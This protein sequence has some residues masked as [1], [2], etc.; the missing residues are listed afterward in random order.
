MNEISTDTDVIWSLDP[1]IGQGLFTPEAQ[2]DSTE[3]PLT[4]SLSN[5]SNYDFPKGQIFQYNLSVTAH[6]LNE[7]SVDLGHHTGTYDKL[8]NV[9]I[10]DQWAF[11]PDSVAANPLAFHPNDA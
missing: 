9:H 4:L 6:I 1:I 11:I 5:P 2:F 8:I 7:S 10:C 3:R